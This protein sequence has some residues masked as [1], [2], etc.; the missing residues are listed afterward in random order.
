M[1]GDEDYNVLRSASIARDLLNAG[2]SVQLGAHG[3]LAGLGSQWEL[4]LLAESGMRPLDALKCATINGAKYLGLDKDLGSVES[5]K[6]ADLIVLDRNPLEGIRTSE[7]VR[8]TILNGRLYDAMT[9]NEIGPRP[10]ERRP[11]F[12]ER[13]LSSMGVGADNSHCAG[14]GRPGAGG[15]DHEPEV[16]EPQAYR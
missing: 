8:Y 7:S 14:C 1:A 12:F 5:G 2:V 10:K 15:T 16:P 3:Q 11:F 9:M 4:W 13:V 6:L